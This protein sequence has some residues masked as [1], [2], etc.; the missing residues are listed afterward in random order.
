MTNHD[1]LVLGIATLWLLTNFCG[2]AFTLRHIHN[3]RGKQ[4]K[5]KKRLG[6][7]LRIP[8]MRFTLPSMRPI[9]HN[10]RESLSNLLHSLANL[11]QR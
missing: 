6:N 7:C 8:Q 1:Y 3:H 4:D 11:L 9:L 2:A 5:A 10:G